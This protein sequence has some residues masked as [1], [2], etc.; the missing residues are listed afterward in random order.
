[1]QLEVELHALEKEEDKASKAR[2]VD[3]SVDVEFFFLPRVGDIFDNEHIS[4]LR[5]M[6][7]VRV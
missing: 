7:N 6:L 2:L 3:V 5:A 4:I 1:M